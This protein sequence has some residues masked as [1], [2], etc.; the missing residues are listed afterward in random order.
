[1]ASILDRD[2]YEG[3]FLDRLEQVELLVDDLAKRAKT[4]TVTLVE[5]NTGDVTNPP[6]DVE[7]KKMAY[8]FVRTIPNTWLKSVV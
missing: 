2:H 7:Q 4:G 6:T 8:L 1:M 3:N 5:V